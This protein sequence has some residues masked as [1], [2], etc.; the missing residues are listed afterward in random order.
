M[1]FRS[2]VKIIWVS[3]TTTTKCLEILLKNALLFFCRN[4]G[5]TEHELTTIPPSLIRGFMKNGKGGFGSQLPGRFGRL[6]MRGE[7]N[8]DLYGPLQE[9]YAKGESAGTDV[10]IHKNR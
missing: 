1:L 6:L 10:W 7:L 5:L 4:W 2:G 9:E 3:V 8:S